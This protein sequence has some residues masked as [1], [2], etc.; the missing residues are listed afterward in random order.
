MERERKEGGR[1]KERERRREEERMKRGREIAEEAW[2]DHF[3]LLLF[4]LHLH[5]TS[6][7][8]SLAVFRFRTVRNILFSI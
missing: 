2:M 1:G 8:K 7:F 6:Y 5:P 4:S 3:C